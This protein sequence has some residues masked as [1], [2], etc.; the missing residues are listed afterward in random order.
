M[1]GSWKEFNDWALALCV[2]ASVISKIL[3]HVSSW[4]VEKEVETRNIIYMFTILIK[5]SLS[6][7]TTNIN[8]LY[9]WLSLGSNLIRFSRWVLSGHNILSCACYNLI[10]PNLR[11]IDILWGRKVHCNGWLVQI[12]LNWPKWF[13][14]RVKLNLCSLENAVVCMFPL[15][16]T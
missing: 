5:E 7:D 9:I 2:H 6:A 10:K 4:L 15:F 1:V 14:I 16:Y 12:I 11:P 8:S 13:H 3:K